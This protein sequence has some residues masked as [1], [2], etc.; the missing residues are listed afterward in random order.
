MIKQEIVPGLNRGD[1]KIEN[2]K[3]YLISYCYSISRLWSNY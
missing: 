3:S 2:I 1:G